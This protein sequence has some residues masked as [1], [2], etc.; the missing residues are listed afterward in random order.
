MFAPEYT[1]YILSFYG[2]TAVTGS[3]TASPCKGSSKYT[4]DCGEVT[5]KPR[6]TGKASKA[7]RQAG[8][9]APEFREYSLNKKLVKQKMFAFYHLEGKAKYFRLWTLTFPAGTQDYIAYKLH[10]NF[11]TRLR[12][13]LGLTSYIWVAE[14]QKNSTLH[15]HFIFAQYLDIREANYYAQKAI[16][17]AIKRGEI[18]AN[19]SEYKY[20][21]GLDVSKKVGNFQS[22]AKYLTKYVTKNNTTCARLP[23]YCSVDIS[24]LFTTSVFSPEEIEE[25]IAQNALKITEKPIFE[26]EY[27]AF[28]GIISIDIAKI[29]APLFSLNNYI[30]SLQNPS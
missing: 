28:F 20:Y 2:C 22:V 10:N 19:L 25:I 6:P 14:R 13:E 4:V 1:G 12:T 17:N 21:N 30:Y 8:K 26:S 27:F 9:Q 5:D 18:V 24:R 3:S 15:F 11:L 16:N 29:F 23:Y 7:S